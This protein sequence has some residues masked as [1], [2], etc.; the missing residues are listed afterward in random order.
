MK[1]LY[2]VLL[3]LTVSVNAMEE[4]DLDL[5]SNKKIEKKEKK[6]NKVKRFFSKKKKKTNAVPADVIAP[7]EVKAPEKSEDQ[8]QDDSIKIKFPAARNILSMF[9]QKKV[10]S[11]D[12]TNYV[13]KKLGNQLH[14]YT[15]DEIITIVNDAF[16][17]HSDALKHYATPLTKRMVF[18]IIL[19]NNPEAMSYLE[20][21][22]LLD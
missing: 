12:F 6:G 18:E 5:G 21:N 4:E 20:N 11:N 17:Q 19:P 3:A 10:S 22:N 8:E 14:E 13:A 15:V 9:A 7:E 2:V 16:K 1:I